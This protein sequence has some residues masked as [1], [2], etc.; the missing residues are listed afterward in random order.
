MVPLS[1]FDLATG[2]LKK[3]RKVINRM[4][5]EGWRFEIWQPEEVAA[6][7][8]ELRTISDA[9][10]AHTDAREKGF[11]LGRF[12]E[13][14]LCRLPVAVLIVS[15]R[16]VAFVEELKSPFEVD[17]RFF[18][19]VASRGGGCAGAFCRRRSGWGRRLRRR[20]GRV[21]VRRHRRARLERRGQDA[22]RGKSAYTTE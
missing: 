6:R 19:R 17:R 16:V 20:C 9:W 7:I 4:E 11:S 3:F 21:A 12:D 10:L 14:Y 22:H 18:V 5:R 8:A 13:A 1:T 2:E 15:E